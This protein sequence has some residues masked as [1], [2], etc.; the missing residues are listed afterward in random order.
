MGKQ[1]GRQER[2]PVVWMV[3]HGL[4]ASA[5]GIAAGLAIDWFPE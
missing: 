3:V 1:R 4:I 5:F 2:T